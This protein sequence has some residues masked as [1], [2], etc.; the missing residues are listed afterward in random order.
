MNYLPREVLTHSGL[1]KG[2]YVRYDAINNMHVV[3]LKSGKLLASHTLGTMFC[4][5]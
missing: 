2:M 1:I 4:L 3:L 5:N